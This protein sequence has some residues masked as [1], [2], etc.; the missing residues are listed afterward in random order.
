MIPDANQ[1]R[2][3][4]LTAGQLRY[5]DRNIQSYA[6]ICIDFMPIAEREKIGMRWQLML[7]NLVIM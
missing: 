4:F 6:N 3:G 2:N 5:L 7:R 1:H